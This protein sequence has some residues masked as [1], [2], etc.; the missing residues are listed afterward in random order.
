MPVPMNKLRVATF[1][2]YIII[3]GA[4][5]CFLITELGHLWLDM[6]TNL[7]VRLWELLAEKSADILS[8]CISFYYY[9]YYWS[10]R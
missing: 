7:H 2:H 6:P 9:L 10:N 1:H 3:G 4:A 8:F 5:V